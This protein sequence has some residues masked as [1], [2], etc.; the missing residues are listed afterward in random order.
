MTAEPATKLPDRGTLFISADLEGCAAVSGPGGLAPERWAWEWHAARRWMT[1]EVVAVSEAALLSGYSRVI[2]ADS[3]GNAH[4]IEPDQ[5]PENVYLVR[6]WP[7][8]LLHMQGVE[9][10]AVTACAFVGAHGGATDIGFLAHSFHG[11]VFRAVRLNGVECSEGY[12][13]AALAGEFR[14]PIIFV[15]GDLSAVEDAKRYAPS[16][17][18]HVTKTMVGWRSQMSAPPKQVRR[19][20]FEAARDKFAAGELNE[21]FQPSGPYVLQLEFVKQI[22]AELFAYWPTVART[23][24]FTIEIEVRNLVEATRILAFAMLYTPTGIALGD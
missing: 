18:T 4:N 21:P 2:V 24:A 5:L 1:D 16:A 17:G 8:P 20:L 14:R 6:S 13:N 19:D 12:F 3:H 11:G 23:N 7:R 10:A 22:T 9:D 15:A